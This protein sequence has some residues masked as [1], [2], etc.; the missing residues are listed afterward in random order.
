MT[1]IPLYQR[2]GNGRWGIDSPTGLFAVVDDA[3]VPL[4]ADRIWRLHSAGYAVSFIGGQTVLMHRLIL[5]L[6]PGD[7]VHT[8]H[9]NRNRL[10]NRRENLRAGTQAENNRNMGPRQR[11]LPP[12]VNRFR[13]RYR[14]F[15]GPRHLGMFDTVDE[16]AT[17]SAAARADRG[18]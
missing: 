3:D 15:I 17:V 16:A 2:T 18:W 1:Q 9:I 4:V 8:D 11:D 10:D 6:Q 13:G 12:G 5:G 14:A 7:H